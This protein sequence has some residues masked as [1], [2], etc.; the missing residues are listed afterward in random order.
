[1]QVHTWCAVCDCILKQTACKLTGTTLQATQLVT[2]RTCQQNVATR[3]R[4]PGGAGRGGAEPA[5]RCP[6][7][8]PDVPGALSGPAARHMAAPRGRGLT[9]AAV[10]A[11]RHAQETVC[12]RNRASILPSVKTQ[13]NLVLCAHARPIHRAVHGLGLLVPTPWLDPSPWCARRLLLRGGE[14]TE[15]LLG[16]G[17]AILPRCRTLPSTATVRPACPRVSRPRTCAPRDVRQDY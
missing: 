13:A 17:A 3:T 9:G 8:A 15:G 14:R 2:S 1:V 6:S 11:G 5:A 4:I 10:A 12:Q 7:A 16:S